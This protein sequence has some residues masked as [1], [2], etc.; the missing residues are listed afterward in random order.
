MKRGRALALAASGAAVVGFPALVR[1]QTSTLRLAASAA[2]TQAEGYFA[3]QLGYFKQAGITVT[4][5]TTARGAETLAG[6][7]RGDLDIASAT[8]QGVA[9]AIIHNIPLR[10]IAIGAIYVDPPAVGLYVA[11]ASKIGRAADLSN[12][13]VAVNSLNDS[14][15]LGVWQWMT[16][17][18][19]DP[20]TVKIVEIPFSA[21]GAALK[22]GEVAAGCLV[23]PFA[24]AASKEDAR[25]VPGVYA[26]LGRHWALG[27]W[28]AQKDFIDKNPALIKAAVTALYATGKHVNANPASVEQLL[29]TY[30][31]LPLETIRAI[32]RPVWAERVERSSI[33]PQLVSA[34]KFKVISRPVSFDEIMLS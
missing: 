15:S 12:T 6:I 23:E 9:N 20:S 31:K 18:K 19:V 26:S 27:V 1:A 5:N 33:E 14:Q 29:V 4:I 2:A 24:T 7:S 32:V 11:K 21:I 17:N 13:T 28:Y 30:T 10:I 34:A 22:R 25:V 16:D 3:D 8:P